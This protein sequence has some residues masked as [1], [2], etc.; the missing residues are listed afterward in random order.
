MTGMHTPLRG[1]TYDETEKA[2]ADL[3]EKTFRAA[4]VFDWVHAKRV[5]E[6]D[7]MTNLPKA[8][9]AHLAEN[10][11]IAVPEILRT[12]RSK[13]DGTAKY[14]FRLSDGECI[15]SV[16]MPYRFG[17]TVCVSSQAGCAMGCAFCASCADGLK[18][19]LMADEMLSQVYALADAEEGTVTHVVVMGMGEPLQNTDNL[20]RFVTI[21]S[22][23]RGMHL[24]RRHITV[25]TC[26]IV[27][28][29][30]RIAREIPQI[31]LA[32][33]LHA[34]T[35]EKRE[36]IMP[37]ARMYPLPE[38]MDA[39]AAYSRQ[40][41]RQITFE[42]ALIRGVNDSDEDAANL[43]ALLPEISRTVNLIPVNPVRGNGFTGPE[44]TDVLKFKK[45]LE[46]MG[47]HVTIRRELGR[48]INGAC[49][50]LARK[51][52]EDFFC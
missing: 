26:G 22:D 41:G 37:V 32:V 18:R 44:R 52:R 34:A 17:N 31:N 13:A 48:D 21:L 10:H 11:T 50:Q 43:A 8:L 36:R 3:G 2:L 6:F 12:E 30:A 24:G 47:I 40:T 1:M 20:I 5:T 49:G 35:Q 16:C 15:E 25:S 45:N 7:H 19:N 14:L 38:L 51:H 29:I 28:Q 4:Q 42:Y 39:C 27:P 46:K 33:S 23:E 9:R